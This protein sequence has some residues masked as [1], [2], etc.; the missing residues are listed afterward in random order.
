MTEAMIG[1]VLNYG[2]LGVITI[3]FFRSYYE[4][5][6]DSK[7]FQEKLLDN[8]KQMAIILSQTMDTVA[9]NNSI[10]KNTENMHK[11]MDKKLEKIENT[12]NS[13]VE[14]SNQYEVIQAVTSIKEML[15]EIF[16]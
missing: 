6:E 2:V 5:K 7:R 12:L 14:S 16:E 13:L 1:A 11:E 10:I 8:E 15:I 3:I 4:D 9:K